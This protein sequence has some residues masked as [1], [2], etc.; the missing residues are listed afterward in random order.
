MSKIFPVWTVHRNND[1]RYN[2]PV[3]DVCSTEKHALAVASGSGWYGGN[4]PVLKRWAVE[5]DS[6]IYLLADGPYPIDLDGT[7]KAQREALKET[8][9][10]KL[11]PEEIEALGLNKE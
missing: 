9:L 10:K 7:M 1:E 6:N 4:A 11:S 5:V 2:G 3:T 8:A